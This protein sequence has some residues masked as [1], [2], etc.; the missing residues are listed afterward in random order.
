MGLHEGNFAYG[1]AQ[2]SYSFGFA[3]SGRVLSD[4]SAKQLDNVLCE[5]VMFRNNPLS[6]GDIRFGGPGVALGGMSL[7]AGE[8]SPWI[9]VKNLN[10]IYII[11]DDTT[12]YLEY[13]LVR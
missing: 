7:Q 4:T 11:G 9:P 5:Q 10:L 1:G 6:T 12:S 2:R 3:N 8:W 13:F